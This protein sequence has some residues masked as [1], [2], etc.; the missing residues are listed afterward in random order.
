[1]KIR[2]SLERKDAEV[3]QGWLT[4]EP[5]ERKH[6]ILEVLVDGQ[7]VG[8]VEANVF[9][10]DVKEAGFGDGACGF[11]F[12][13]PPDL[14]PA[15]AAE[16]R[17]RLLATELYLSKHQEEAAAA[18]APETPPGTGSVFILGP[19]RSGTSITFLALKS[20]LKL[21]G[22]GEGH[23]LPIFQRMLFSYYQHTK[24]FAGQPGVLAARLQVATLEEHM[25]AFL[26]RFYFDQFGGE[27]FIDKTPGLEALVGAPFVRQVFPGAKIIV[28]TRNGVEVVDSYRR[29]FGAS[30]ED[31]CKEFAQ[32]AR[33]TEAL[34]SK[35]PDILF[36]DQN[37]MRAK[38][39]AAAAKLAS[40]VDL[41]ET[42]VDIELFLRRSRED[43]LSDPRAWDLPLTPDTA[44]WTTEEKALYSQQCS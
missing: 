4:V 5:S 9:R 14:D 43:V 32:C 3:I 24:Q 44:G 21:P 38:P 35:M 7:P 17:V 23:V 37:E 36:L 13:F 25:I 30:F 18:K 27:R 6:Q 34:R 1:M 11:V 22:L 28:M 40:H 39:E 26:R 12:R 16:A 33:Q 31:A 15:K 20:A 8:Q 2:G 42:A 10:P 19:A 29:K 41:P